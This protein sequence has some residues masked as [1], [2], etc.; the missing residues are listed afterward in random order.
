MSNVLNEEK[1]QQVLVLGRLQWSLRR[2]EKQTGVRRETV[3]AY[4]KA[5]GIAVR[6]RGRPGRGGVSS[7]SREAEADS[8]AAKPANQVTTDPGGGTRR[9]TASSTDRSLSQRQYL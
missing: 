7:P 5:A 1:Q 8:T 6:G 2:I 4:L 9:E 3:S